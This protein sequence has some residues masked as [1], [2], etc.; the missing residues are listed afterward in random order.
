[1]AASFPRHLKRT[2][3]R[4]RTKNGYKAAAEMKTGEYAPEVDELEKERVAGEPKEICGGQCGREYTLTT[5][6]KYDGMCC[7]CRT[8]ELQTTGGEYT[9]KNALNKGLY[10]SATDNL[11]DKDSDEETE[12]E[13][14]SG[15]SS[16]DDSDYEAEKEE[17][18]RSKPKP[19]RKA[20][21]KAKAKSKWPKVIDDTNFVVD[22]E[23]VH[24]EYERKDKRPPKNELEEEAFDLAHTTSLIQDKPKNPKRRRGGGGD[25]M[26]EKHQ[27]EPDEKR[28]KTEWREDAR[29]LATEAASKL[30]AI[31]WT[32]K[33]SGELIKEVGVIKTQLGL[34]ERFLE[35]V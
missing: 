28:K 2:T 3:K 29:Y 34:I 19:K 4:E 35:R 11:S 23:T 25:E 14:E 32:H 15:S 17:K 18:E 10:K 12:S 33:S 30:I 8:A 13:N 31:D 5:L 7:L 26:D 9:D 22:D 16:S 21:P 1:M 27:G 24:Y 6:K 20:K